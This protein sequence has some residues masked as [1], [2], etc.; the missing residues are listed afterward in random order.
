MLPNL[1]IIELDNF[2]QL[3]VLNPKFRKQHLSAVLECVSY[4]NFESSHEVHILFNGLR[5]LFSSILPTQKIIKQLL[6]L[7][8]KKG[9]FEEKMVEDFI[10][11]ILSN[12]MTF[13]N[14]CL[15]IG[16]SV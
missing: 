16:M 2:W 6:E 1:S 5:K 10:L 4:L 11:C 14:E 9:G 12:W 8:I 7:P 15:N 13:S 3:L